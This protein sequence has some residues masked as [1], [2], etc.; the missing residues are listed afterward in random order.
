MSLIGENLIRLVRQF[1]ATTPER[2]YVA[3]QG[4]SGRCLYVFDGKPSCLVGMALWE[5]GIIGPA[6]EHNAGNNKS[7]GEIFTRLGLALD[8]NE[9]NWL[10]NVQAEQDMMI[11]WGVAVMK[12]DARQMNERKRD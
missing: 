7:I 1:A 4:A 12:A 6:Y 8:E 3:P 9:A 5:A 10:R 2:V 11:P